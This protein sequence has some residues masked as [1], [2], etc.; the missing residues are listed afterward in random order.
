M[1]FLM[2]L[3]PPVLAL[4]VL[5]VL[6][7]HA[8]LADTRIEVWTLIHDGKVDEVRVRLAVADL[9]DQRDAFGAFVTSDPVVDAFSAGLLADHPD[10][11][12]AMTARGWALYSQ[13]WAMRGTGVGMSVFPEAAARMQ[14]L[15]ENA[16]T[17][18]R[19]ALNKDPTLIPA[20][21]L[22]MQVSKTLRETELVPDE[23]ARAMAITP[24][25]QTLM[26]A[27]EALAPR[28]GGSVEFGFQACKN[29]GD[30]I[31]D[32]PGYSAKLCRLDVLWGAGYPDEVRNEFLDELMQDTT[33]ILDQSRIFE[34]RANS[35]V[36]DEAALRVFQATEDTGLLQLQDYRKWDA[37]E[38]DTGTGD[39][40]PRAARALPAELDRLRQEA[41]FD[42]GDGLAL[43]TYLRIL[44]YQNDGA[45]PPLSQADIKTR[46]AQ[47]LA[48]APY[49]AGTWAQFAWYVELGTSKETM[50]LASVDRLRGYYANAVAYSNQNRQVLHFLD[51]FN[52][53]VWKAMDKRNTDAFDISG[54]P[55]FSADDY[56][57]SIVC[58]AIRAIRLIQETC[59][60]G[61][62][63]QR[64]NIYPEG[65][66]P[67][68]AM[69]ERAE[70]RQTCTNE[71]T[72]DPG[73]LA[74]TPVTVDILPAP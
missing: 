18:A 47:L 62:T 42:P 69:L 1:R 30:R 43:M 6:P 41:D 16:A 51:S 28:W 17:L 15:H 49:D 68:P 64:C 13:G 55:E 14:D 2:M 54:A 37:M 21:D 36:T 57:R 60:E 7:P 72:A 70:R 33:S 61:S 67:H 38:G 23:M 53:Q 24:N 20:S 25:R 10:D 45:D 58:P 66:D 34:A 65:A 63:D 31:I 22:L 59:P 8:S 50:T 40:G 35:L 71:L 11:A 73:D 27:A 56:N 12:Q 3:F 32:V 29:W 44:D 5:M 74:Y 48:I 19:A 26:I 4:S 9:A 52:Q 46:F 39:L